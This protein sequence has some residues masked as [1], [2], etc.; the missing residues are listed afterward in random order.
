MVFLPTTHCKLQYLKDSGNFPIDGFKKIQV[1]N[2]INLSMRRELLSHIFYLKLIGV[3]IT[4]GD[5][6][7]DGSNLGPIFGAAARPLAPCGFHHR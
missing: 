4:I 6:N 3:A 5:S 7:D 2:E 1:L